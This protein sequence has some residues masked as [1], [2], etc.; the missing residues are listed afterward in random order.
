MKIIFSGYLILIVVSLKNFSIHE[1]NKLNDTE[2]DYS[3]RFIL[4]ELG[5]EIR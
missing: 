1:I 3:S 2:L 4:S 5:V